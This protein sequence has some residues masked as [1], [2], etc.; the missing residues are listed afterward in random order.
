MDHMLQTIELAK[1]GSGY[2]SPNPLVGAV[3]VRGGKVIANGYHQKAGTNHAEIVALKK[4]GKKA[5]GATLYI[6]LEPCCHIGKTPA[7]TRAIIKAGVKQ[8]H[9]AVLD[10]NPLVSGKGKLILE[11]VG[12][13]VVVGEHEKE[14]RELNEIFFKYITTKKPFVLAKWAMSLDGQLTTPPGTQQWISS[15]ASQARAHQLRQ[16]YDAILV[17]VNTVIADNPSLTVRHGI[18]KPAHPLR[19]ILDSSGRTPLD[20]KIFTKNMPGKTLIATT[21]LVNK[22]RVQQFQQRGIEV[23]AVNSGR[24]VNFKQL[25]GQ[26]ATRGITSV[27]VEGGATVLQSAFRTS[28]VDKVMLF[29][30]PVVLG[31]AINNNKNI[32][33][34]NQLKIT[35]VEAIAGDVLITAYPK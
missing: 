18:K 9:C 3:L 15:V 31:G 2:T 35:N 25:L 32:S 20:A 17:G 12:I 7:C 5:A 13:K 16:R 4:A 29:L 21:T 30:A 19:V 10:P 8:V 1:K 26:L 6:N 34:L 28:S 23:L 33:L 22:K 27:L 11:R 14:A 24:T